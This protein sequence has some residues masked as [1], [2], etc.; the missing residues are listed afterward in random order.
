MEMETIDPS[1]TGRAERRQVLT[2][3]A[4]A[5]EPELAAFATR[6]AQVLSLLARREF[7]LASRLFFVAYFADR[8]SISDELLQPLHEQL[9]QA[10]L[11][12]T[13]TATILIVILGARLAT[14]VPPNFRRLLDSTVGGDLRHVGA[15]PAGDT[16]ADLRALG[17]GRLWSVHR[18]RRFDDARI[19]AY[20]ERYCR[21]FFHG[22]WYLR[23][24]SLLVHL[25]SL[26]VRLAVLRWLLF[27]HP[28]VKTDPSA[29]AVEVVY[30]FSRAVEHSDEL[31]QTIIR[32]LT[33]TK[34]TTI[35]HAAT[36]LRF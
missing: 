22:D 6:R 3:E 19:E 36:L 29:A 8:Q 9:Q 18:A 34:T 27:A 32:A 4:Q 23:S 17:P 26:L 15:T 24:P 21:H 35:A 2:E 13:L 31:S 11:D 1:L 14:R 25:N 12:A 5:R 20:L 33:E 28:A 16:L 30:S 7:P 10:T